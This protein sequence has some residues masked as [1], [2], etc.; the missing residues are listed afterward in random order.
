MREVLDALAWPE[1]AE[2]AS[3]WR[4]WAISAGVVG[5]MFATMYVVAVFIASL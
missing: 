3:N 4:T 2:A 5:G 1:L